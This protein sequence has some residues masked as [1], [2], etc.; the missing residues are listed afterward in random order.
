MDKIINPED[1]ELSL[2]C[3]QYSLPSSSNFKWEEHRRQLPH[4]AISYNT[5]V[6]VSDVTGHQARAVIDM[7][8]KEI[9]TTS[10]EIDGGDDGLPFPA[11]AAEARD[12]RVRNPALCMKRSL[13]RFL[14]KRKARMASYRSSARGYRQPLQLFST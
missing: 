6:C 12:R 9:M 1:L 5:G 4:M 13:Q 7:V 10:D 8:K 14:E 3:R 2:G 11:A